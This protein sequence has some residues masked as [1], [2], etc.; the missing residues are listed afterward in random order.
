MDAPLSIAL[1]RAITALS[2]SLPDLAM[3]SC[4]LQWLDGGDGDGGGDAD[5]VAMR[6]LPGRTCLSRRALVTALK[7]MTRLGLGEVAGA[8][9]AKVVRL[10]PAGVER[11]D[12]LR[13]VVSALGSD[14]PGVEGM[15]SALVEIVSRLELEHPHF[16]VQYGTADCSI[17]GGPGQDWKPVPRVDAAGVPDLPLSALLSQAWVALAIEYEKTNGALAWVANVLSLVPD[18]GL[19]VA[20]VPPAGASV[21]AGLERHG[22]IRVADG[23]VHLTP[24]GK[25]SRDWHQPKLEEIDVFWRR[26]FGDAAVDGLASSLAM[27]LAALPPIDDVRCPPLRAVFG[28]SG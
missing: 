11:R 27:A 2:S 5:G 20:S 13:P 23:V 14:W 18:D 25:R 24:V 7:G 21:L 6:A 9:S 8:G 12:S 22:R 1:A 4:V 15:R 16:P 10:T 28:M 26:W 17:R 19:P 3:W